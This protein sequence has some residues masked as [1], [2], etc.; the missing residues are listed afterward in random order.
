MCILED[1]NVDLDEILN[2]YMKRIDKE[3]K[4]INRIKRFYHD[5][6]TFNNLMNIIIEK[7]AKRIFKFLHSKV[8]TP[9]IENN[10][11]TPWQIFYIILDIVQNEGEIIPPFD[12]LTSMFLS[13]TMVY[14]G[15]TF[16]WVHGEN[17]IISVYNKSDDLVYRF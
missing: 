3:N 6:E 12:K 4:N 8:S 7:D 5:E 14:M 13:R 2:Y 1:E 15:W 17:T 16:S 10:L 9:N 11:P